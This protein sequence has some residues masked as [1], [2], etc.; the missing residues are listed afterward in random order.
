[1]R[2]IRTVCILLFAAIIMFLVSCSKEGPEGPQGP[3]GPQGE[4]GAAGSTGA[5]GEQGPKGDTGT[6]NVIYSTWLDVAYTPDTVYVGGIIDTVGF[7]A[8]IAA[9]KLDSAILS[10]GDMHVYLNISDTINPNVVALPYFDVLSG[11][12]IIPSFQ[13]Q[14]ISL[15]ANGNVSTRT[16][17]SGQKILQYR[18]VLI[19]GGVSGNAVIHP[20]DWNNYKLVK[21]FYHLPD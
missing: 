11:L 12:S 17:Q 20:P 9:N 1:M 3:Q 2:Q 16:S 7:Y 13:L 19:P 6:A 14:N 4:P 5:T 18:Y 10:G 21:E 8:A 15:Y